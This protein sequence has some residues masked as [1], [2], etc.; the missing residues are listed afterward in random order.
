[1]SRDPLGMVD[2]PN[3]YMYVLNRPLNYIDP[4]GDTTMAMAGAGGGVGSA[5]GPVGTVVGAVIG[6]LA[7]AAALIFGFRAISERIAAKPVLVTPT[8]V[9]PSPPPSRAPSPRPILDCPRS[10]PREHDPRCDEDYDRDVAMCALVPLKRREACYRQA[11]ER[12]GNCIA[13]GWPSTLPF[14]YP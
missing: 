5:L 7:G 14:P 13:H 2:G 3:W 12:H 10:G 4:M 8:P 6:F 1:M 9:A 11:A